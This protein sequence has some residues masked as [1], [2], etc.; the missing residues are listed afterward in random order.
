MSTRGGSPYVSFSNYNGGNGNNNQQGGYKNFDQNQPDQISPQLIGGG[1]S[2][3]PNLPQPEFQ[4]PNTVRPT[5]GVRPNGNPKNEYE[6]SM[7]QQYFQVP[8]SYQNAQPPSQQQNHHQS[9][10]QNGGNMNDESISA[11]SHPHRVREIESEKLF[12]LLTNR[13]YHIT[14]QNKPMKIFV[15]VYT[16]W[17][18][19]CRQIAPRINE[20]SMNPEFSDILF[21][22][23]NG[24]QICD[25]LAQVIKVSAVPV[26]FGFVGGKKIDFIP[27]PDY[28]KIVG[29]CKYMASM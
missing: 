13:N 18:K 21:V 1:G 11:P 22:K 24:E 27:G 12:H 16:D 9:Y 17:C 5:Q 29:L 6:S 3:P 23:I 7:Q 4:V 14:P 8:P 26:F 20:L 2:P 19:P 25:K 10:P 28:E 15:K